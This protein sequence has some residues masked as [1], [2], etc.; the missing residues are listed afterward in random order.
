MSKRE[1]LKVLLF[2]FIT[3]V[4][5]ITVCSRSS[6][7]YPLNDW[8]DANCFF[9][10]GKAMMN[11]KVLYRDLFEQKGPF[12]YFLHGLAWLISHDSFMGVYFIEI[13]ACFFFLFYSYK[14]LRMTCGPEV[15]VLIPFWAAFLYGS[16]AFCAGDS[17]EELCLPIYAYAIY[18]SLKSI[19]YKEDISYKTCFVIGLLSGAILWSKFTLLGIFCGW[20]VIPAGNLICRKEWKRLWKMFGIISLGI[21]TVT[22]PFVFYFEYHHAVRDWLDVYLYKNI[23]YYSVADTE[24]H[25]FIERIISNLWNGVRRTG[26]T[27]LGAVVFIILG[28]IYLVCTEKKQIVCHVNLML[29]CTFVL[30]FIGGR[31]YNYYPFILGA[32]SVWGGWN[33]LASVVWKERSRWSS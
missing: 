25:A 15:M 4:G 3:S 5:V 13:G 2:L 27:Y 23:F 1:H 14:I 30:V 33:G 31:N 19:K 20:I 7:L 8:D 6:F 21:L 28:E 26:K 29:I 24:K 11:G 22:I 10:M 16:I 12:L 9:T 17:V 32:F 18:T